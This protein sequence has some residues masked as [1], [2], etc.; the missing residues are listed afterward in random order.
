MLPV[1]AALEENK[2]ISS[3]G[4]PA[5]VHASLPRSCR[6]MQSAC[7]EQWGTVKAREMSAAQQKQTVH[8]SRTTLSQRNLNLTLCFSRLWLTWPL[9]SKRHLLSAGFISSWGRVLAMRSKH[10]VYN[11]IY[12]QYVTDPS[13]YLNIQKYEL[14]ECFPTGNLKSFTSGRIKEY[15]HEI[16]CCLWHFLPA[17][18][19]WKHRPDDTNNPMLHVTFKGLGNRGK[20]RMK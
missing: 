13:G 15:L 11:S 1:L 5:W 20:Q 8:D 9:E 19:P 12:L 17:H 14:R 4:I 2:S 10:K 7:G 16:C 3:S 18:V 6:T